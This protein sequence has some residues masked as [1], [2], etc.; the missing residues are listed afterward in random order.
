MAT[1]NNITKNALLDL[2]IE[3]HG[4]LERWREISSLDARVSVG[5]AL[6]R[7][8]NKPHGLEDVTMRVDTRR[9]DL[10]TWPYPDADHVGR[11]LPDRVWI[12]DWAGR[13]V[14]ERAKPRE[15]FAGHVWKTPWDDLHRLY[16]TSYAFWN[17]F[18]TPFLFAEPG[19]SVREIE[20]H[21]EAGATWRRLVVSFPPTVPTHSPEQTFYFNDKGLLQRIDYVTDVAGGVGAHYCFDHQNF[22]GI[23]FPTLRRIVNRTP[24]G[25]DIFGPTGVLIRIWDI[26]VK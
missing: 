15:S 11:F 8:K 5:G 25:P 19:F 20:P 12:E 21:D 4:G 26:A 7:V 18:T 3:A 14:D 17:Y 16:F 10:T 23:I 22:G 1:A 6:F 24:A 9:P 2:A 13:V